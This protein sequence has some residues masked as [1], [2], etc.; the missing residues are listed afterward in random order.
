MKVVTQ[1]GLLDIN[2][3][4]VIS[5]RPASVRPDNMNFCDLTYCLEFKDDSAP[6]GY[7]FVCISETDAEKNFRAFGNPDSAKKKTGGEQ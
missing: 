1:L 2:P 4:D 7:N 6:Y 3:A 5:I